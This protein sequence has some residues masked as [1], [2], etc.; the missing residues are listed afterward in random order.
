MP[1]GRPDE[2]LTVE[3][4]VPLLVGPEPPQ[5]L[6]SPS[7][8]ACSHFVGT[9]GLLAIDLGGKALHQLQGQIFSFLVVW[10]DFVRADY[11]RASHDLVRYGVLMVALVHPIL[12][13]KSAQPLLDVQLAPSKNEF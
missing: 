1:S 2:Y 4:E 11:Q 6:H 5:H 12:A 8:A 3:W 9:S 10:L 7:C 13:V